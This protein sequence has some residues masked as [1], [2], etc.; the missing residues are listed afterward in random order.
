MIASAGDEVVKLES[1]HIPG[2]IVKWH[3]HFG[4]G[5]EWDDLGEWH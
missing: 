3:S 1:S 4:K 2:G 5:R